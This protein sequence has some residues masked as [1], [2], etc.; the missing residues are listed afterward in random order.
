M[1]D[2]EEPQFN[3]EDATIFEAE[4][5][6][7]IADASQSQAHDPT[8]LLRKVLNLPDLTPEQ[9]ADV[10]MIQAAIEVV[11]T[12]IIDSLEAH[13][14]PLRVDPT[15]NASDSLETIN[16]LLDQVKNENDLALARATVA[17]SAMIDR[18]E[19]DSD[20]D[21]DERARQYNDLMRRMLCI[22]YA[23]EMAE[24][25][26]DPNSMLSPEEVFANI[27]FEIDQP[28]WIGPQE[29]LLLSNYLSELCERFGLQVS[30]EELQRKEA[31]QREERAGKEES[32]EAKRQ[33]EMQVLDTLL[34]VLGPGAIYHD[35]WLSTVHTFNRRFDVERL[36]RE[37]EEG[38][39][40]DVIDELGNH[41]KQSS[42]VSLRE[43]LTRLGATNQQIGYIF[44][45]LS[46]EDIS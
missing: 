45:Q 38:I 21:F 27:N 26:V 6:A 33:Y 2:R 46:I 30:T 23:R 15:Q 19:G 40:G 18:A 29:R 4:M 37:Q 20:T 25:V 1:T 42:A 17:D 12:D 31:N 13:G 39:F 7:F 8:D 5:D 32:K 44:E 9:A 22:D 35:D 24:L 28:E 34:G 10:E 3:P 16:Y 41:I 14:L 43:S 36:M 11:W